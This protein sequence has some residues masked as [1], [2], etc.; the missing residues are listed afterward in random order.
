MTKTEKIVDAVLGIRNAICEPAVP[1]HDQEGGRIGN[2]TEAA[3]SVSRALF[4]IAESI[5]SL[6]DAVRE[7]K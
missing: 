4:K 6:A 3:I 5:Q 2:L 7:N 1:F